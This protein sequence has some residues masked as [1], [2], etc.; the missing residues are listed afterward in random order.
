MVISF[1][2][3][4]TYKIWLFPIEKVFSQKKYELMNL[5]H[6]ISLLERNDPIINLLNVIGIKIPNE[7]AERLIDVLKN[8]FFIKKIVLQSNDLEKHYVDRFF[9]L[10]LLNPSI[11]HLEINNNSVDDE[12][13]EF[14]KNVLVQLSP[15]REKINLVLRGNNFGFKGATYLADILNANVPIKCLDIRDNNQITDK[16]IEEI[17]LSLRSNTN[18]TILDII[19]CG[20]GVLGMTAL[21]DALISNNTLQTL[22]IQDEMNFSTIYS[23]CQIL[24]YEFCSLQTLYLWHCQLTTED[25][26][27]LC[28]SLKKNNSLNTLALSFNKI[29]DSGAYCICDMLHKNTTITKLHIGANLFTPT[30]AGFFGVAISN[31][32]VLRTFDISRNFITSNGVW[33]IAVALC[34]TSTLSVLD[35]RYNKINSSSG[36]ILAE[37][38]HNNKSLTILRL[39]GNNL[40]DTTISLLSKTF[41]H[42]KTLAEIELNNVNMTTNGFIEICKALKNNKT[43][44]RISLNQNLFSSGS[45][46]HLKNLLQENTTLQFIGI[47]DCDIYSSG[48]RFIGQGI[49]LNNSLHAIDISKNQIDSEGLKYI[50]DALIG[51]YSLEVMHMI[52]NPFISQNESKKMIM[53]ITNCL[54]R[55]KYYLHNS[56]MKDM[57]GLAS[58]PVLFE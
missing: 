57:A 5:S 38:L 16:G 41:P 11:A 30:S 15:S 21:S 3:D 36:E 37:M 14:L 12:S 17:C 1:E 55:N 50:L 28:S 58:D 39:S 18:L 22:M 48:C 19:S 10:L 27:G 23:L 32:K 47:S 42:N 7:L 26:K 35:L 31:N 4:V 40:G 56:L 49:E 51:N 9:Q 24:S 52:E 34:N 33:P 8:N 29:D 25:V 46:E 53:D 13:L 43:L 45:L 2:C 54:E 44:L 20:C 6:Y